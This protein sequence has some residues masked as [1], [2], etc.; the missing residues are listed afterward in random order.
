[1]R[2]ISQIH[3]SFLINDK[4]IN[5]SSLLFKND[6]ILHN[7]LSF[8]HNLADDTSYSD[9]FE[10]HGIED[11]E[12]ELFQYSILKKA[13]KSTCIVK[14]TYLLGKVMDAKQK[15]NMNLYFSK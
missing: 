2:F 15:E 7:S 8:F 13:A 6:F 9:F 10:K 3:V 5:I 4:F 11:D 14:N 12:A 1:M